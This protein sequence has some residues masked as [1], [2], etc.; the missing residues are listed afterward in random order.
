MTTSARSMGSSARE[1]AVAV[2]LHPAVDGGVFDVFRRPVAVRYIVKAVI[3]LHDILGSA[4]V[5]VKEAHSHGG[6]LGAGDGALP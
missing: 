1:R 6:K 2:A 4:A 3:L 5:H